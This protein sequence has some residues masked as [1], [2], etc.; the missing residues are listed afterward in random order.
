VAFLGFEYDEQADSRIGQ[1]IAELLSE[2]LALNPA[3]KVLGPEVAGDLANGPLPRMAA[4]VRGED[5]ASLGAR[6][7]VDA[8]VTGQAYA[9]EGRFFVVAKVV[10]CASGRVFGA[11]ADGLVQ[12]P[13]TDI[14]EALAPGVDDLL[15][16]RRPELTLPA[17]EVRRAEETTEARVRALSRQREPP[18]VILLVA[19]PEGTAGNPAA[20][21][22]DRLS[23]LVRRIGMTA[24][25][26]RAADLLEWAH[27]VNAGGK[28]EVPGPLRGQGI[29]VAMSLGLEAGEER[30]P[31][32]VANALADVVWLDARDGARLASARLAR[33]ALARG[34]EGAAG[35]AARRVAEAAFRQ[36]FT[37]ALSRWEA[38][39]REEQEGAA[40]GAPAQSP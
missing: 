21:A 13:L 17:G 25:A 19:Q 35:A 8:V 37:A 11:G 14:V 18:P 4:L 24:R 38:R 20:I 30:G 27:A 28:S 40:G 5:V 26:P 6:L 31:L 1:R 12:A 23:Q 16:E 33:P 7:Q 15:A 9:L 10:G 32:N 3:L 39:H 34:G 36:S 22:Q 29:I 2:V